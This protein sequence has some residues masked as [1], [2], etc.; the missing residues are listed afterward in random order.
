M[1]DNHSAQDHDGCCG[2]AHGHHHGHGHGQVIAGPG[3]EVVTCAV[4]GNDTLKS[5]AEKAGL[6]RTFQEQTYYFC[7]GHCA[8]LFDADPSAYALAS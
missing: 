4:K 1:C 5:R 6:V 3:D 7:C 2:G 8:D